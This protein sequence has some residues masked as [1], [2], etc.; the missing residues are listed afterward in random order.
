MDARNSRRAAAA[1]WAKALINKADADTLKEV[2]KVL[3]AS[4]AIE[5]AAVD[6][7]WEEQR[8]TRITGLGAAKTRLRWTICGD[9]WVRP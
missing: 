1:E 6:K 8:K 4:L 2:Q 9:K 7:Y 3:Q 5:D